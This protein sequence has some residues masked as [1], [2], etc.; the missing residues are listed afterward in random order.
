MHLWDSGCQPVGHDPLVA[1]QQFGGPTVWF[2][3]W[4]KLK[5]S[6]TSMTNKNMVFPK[7]QNAKNLSIQKDESIADLKQKDF[8]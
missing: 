1:E 4:G 5:I 3:I 6:K 8:D 2:P 7:A